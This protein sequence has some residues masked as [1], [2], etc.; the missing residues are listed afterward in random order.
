MIIV[1]I[2]T[3]SITVTIVMVA[4]IVF[5]VLLLTMSSRNQLCNVQIKLS[6]EAADDPESLAGSLTEGERYDG[7]DGDNGADD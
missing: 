2:T 4:T 7:D 6:A 5:R 3:V 1:T